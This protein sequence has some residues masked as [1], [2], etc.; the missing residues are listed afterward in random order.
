[1]KVLDC[2]K[3]TLKR[4]INLMFLLVEVWFVLVFVCL[5]GYYTGKLLVGYSD[6]KA[7][8]RSTHQPH[9]Q[10]CQCESLHGFGSYVSTLPQY[11]DGPAFT[12]QP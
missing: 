9:L 2:L 10:F 12:P 4:S 5:R 8:A 3:A 11:Q 1:M 7:H 6:F